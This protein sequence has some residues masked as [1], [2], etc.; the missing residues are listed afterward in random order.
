MA[1]V[2]EKD[3][4]EL[5]ELY[6]TKGRTA[7]YDHIRSQYGLKQPYYVLRRIMKSSRYDYDKEQDLF[8]DPAQSD[9]EQGTGRFVFQSGSALQNRTRSSHR[10]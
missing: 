7:M 9:A 2:K 3:F 6:N 10:I 5:V 4:P 1:V 8:R